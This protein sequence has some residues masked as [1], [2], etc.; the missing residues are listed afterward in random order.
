MV[1]TTQY[2]GPQGV[3]FSSC[4]PKNLYFVKNNDLITLDINNNLLHRNIVDKKNELKNLSHL[5]L[6]YPEFA[7]I[8]F[9]RINMNSVFF[10]W[11]YKSQ[12]F[13]CK[14][15]NST[16]LAGGVVCYH[17]FA[18][19]INAKEI[20]KNFVFRNSITIGNKNNDNSLIPTIGSNVEV[21][22]NAVIIG[23]ITIGDNVLIGAGTIITKDIPSNS[24]VYGNPIIIKNRADD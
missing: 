15:F 24:I 11:F 6:H 2:Q 21:G 4:I 8:F 1:S 18:T 20:G 9:K 13:Y 3:N 17:P 10:N 23:K 19:V 7:F 12:S 5:L 14:I 16:K 22:A